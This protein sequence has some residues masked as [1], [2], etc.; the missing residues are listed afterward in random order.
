MVTAHEITTDIKTSLLLIENNREITY[1]V[2][3]LEDEFTII[4]GRMPPNCSPPG[5]FVHHYLSRAYCGKYRRADCFDI[6]T[7]NATPLEHML[8]A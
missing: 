4:K 6:D 2:I 3:V 7:P 5:C 8:V 1:N